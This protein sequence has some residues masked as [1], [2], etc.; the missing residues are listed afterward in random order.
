MY[1]NLTSAQWHVRGESPTLHLRI[2]RSIRHRFLL[3]FLFI[4]GQNCRGELVS[5]ARDKNARFIRKRVFCG[6]FDIG[7]PK[8]PF[9]SNT[10]I[11]FF[12]QQTA[13][14]P[15]VMQVWTSHERKCRRAESFVTWRRCD[16][17]RRRTFTSS[18]DRKCRRRVGGS[19]VLHMY[20]VA[21]G[22]YRD[23]R[24]E[25]SRVSDMWVARST[26]NPEPL[27]HQSSPW[28]YPPRYTICRNAVGFRGNLSF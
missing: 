23:R 8:F 12:A 18:T 13:G 5:F 15:D 25:V 11:K 14:E 7:R 26:A 24:I 1:H 17:N 21:T 2:L 22:S 20:R 10:L 6:N 28:F 9:G 27:V 16:C 4:S 3:V 19:C